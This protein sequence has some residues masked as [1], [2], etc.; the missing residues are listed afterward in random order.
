MHHGKLGNPQKI[1]EEKECIGNWPYR[2]K[3]GWLSL[4]LDKIGAM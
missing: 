4:W 1:L 3:G 2:F